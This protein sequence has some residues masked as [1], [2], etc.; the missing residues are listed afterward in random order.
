MTSRPLSGENLNTPR[1]QSMGTPAYMIPEQAGLDGLE[2]D[3]RTDIYSLGVLLYELLVGCLPISP[4]EFKDNELLKKAVR[5][6]VPPPPSAKLKELGEQKLVN[7]SHCRQAEPSM[8][9]KSVNGELSRIVMKCL[10]KNREQRFESASGLAT[11]IQW[12][13]NGISSP[14]IKKVSGDLRGKTTPTGSKQNSTWKLIFPAL[15]VIAIV[16]Y[17][18]TS[19]RTPKTLTS[20]DVSTPDG[21]TTITINRINSR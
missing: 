8:L 21:I 3:R 17:V 5:E 2:I 18:F 20:E 10:E 6:I 1:E 19:S 13:L 9:L 7:I 11:D 4:E 16:L 15:L 12:H 14:G